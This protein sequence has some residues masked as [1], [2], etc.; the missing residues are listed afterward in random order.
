MTWASASQK[1]LGMWSL[2][3]EFILQRYRTSFVKGY[4]FSFSSAEYLAKN[5]VTDLAKFSNQ[6]K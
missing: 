3:V 4:L 2:R 6:I 5:N 1:I